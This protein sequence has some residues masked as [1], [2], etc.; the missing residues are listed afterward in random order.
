[1]KPEDT[2]QQ[3]RAL[4]RG[5]LIPIPLRQKAPNIRGW[6]TLTLADSNRYHNELVAAVRRGGNIG[7]VLGPAS[8]RLFA[9]DLDHDELVGKWIASHPWLAK[10]LQSKAKRGCQFWLRLEADCDYPNIKAVYPLKEGRRTI[11]ELRLGGGGGAQSVIFGVHPDGMR[12]QILVE[13]APLVISANDLDEI[14]PDLVNSRPDNSAPKIVN[15]NPSQPVGVMERVR[16][17]LNKCEPAISGQQGHFTIFRVLCRVIAGFDLTP[18]QA[19]EAADYYNGK[20]EPPFREKEL[21]HKI[22]DALE[23][24]AGEARG[25][26]LN[27]V[28]TP[29]SNRVDEER[30]QEEQAKRVAREKR[31]GVDDQATSE[32]ALAVEMGQRVG[33]VKCVGDRWHV[34]EKGFWRPRDKDEFQPLAIEVLSR[35]PEQFRTQ[36]RAKDIQSHLEMRSQAPRSWFCGAMRL[37][38]NGEVMIA[39]QGGML[40]ITANEVQLVE[41]DNALGFTI[42]LP[43]KYNPEAV[44]KVFAHVLAEAVPDPQERE[45]F[46]DVLATA[47]IPDCR[48]ELA[49]VAIGE[50]GTGKSTVASVLPGIFGEACSFLSLGDL[51]HPQG[52]KLSCLENKA[53]NIGTELDALEIDESGLLKQLV[54]GETITVRPIYGR[55]FQM[56]SHA[57]MI[58][59]TNSVPRFRHGTQ[60]EVRRLRFVRFDRKPANPD[61]TLKTRVARDADG[62]FAELVH[63]AQELLAGRAITEPGEW[64]KRT[65]ER[66]AVTNDPIG[67]FVARYC[68][69]APGLQC[70]K[71]HVFSEFVEFREQFGLSDK[72]DE[73]SFFRTLYDRFPAVEQRKPRTGDGRTRI[74]TG[75]AMRDDDDS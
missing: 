23:R 31:N 66:F 14:A 19:R 26:L 67:E 71:A 50:T 47:L 32:Q 28:E 74:L 15:S 59:L 57:K 49:I 45:V 38:A 4:L 35:L 40:V 27:H 51:C 34:W 12:Y 41:T 16:Q 2:I 73:R 61:V 25:Y 64:G 52:Y 22:E 70:D 62:L 21:R 72:L 44:P 11:G 1:M 5:V 7:V 33:M 6:Q 68:S 39:V 48:Y 58:F 13:K 18:E 3:L 60:A 65:A 37:G 9:L 55:P 36:R 24:T 56:Q 63:R 69:I 29:F 30:A 53:L 75:I 10:T 43:V 54:S 8:N 17:Y 46:L 42:A 20:C